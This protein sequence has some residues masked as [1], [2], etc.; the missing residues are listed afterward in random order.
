MNILMLR[1][2]LCNTF[3]DECDKLKFLKI[4]HNLFFLHPSQSIIHNHFPIRR[5]INF[6]AEKALL[7]KLWHEKT[8]L[9]FPTDSTDVLQWFVCL[10]QK[11]E[12]INYKERVSRL[13]C[14]AF[15]FKNLNVYAEQLCTAQAPSCSRYQCYINTPSLIGPSPQLIHYACSVLLR[16][17]PRELAQGSFTVALI[18]RNKH[19]SEVV[20]SDFWHEQVRQIR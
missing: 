4:G 19:E 15:L 11:H 3:D 5:Y 9:I 16:N 8:R 20:T 2:M 12:F 6:T 1:F 13:I 7:N 18:R 10:K 17:Q 14:F